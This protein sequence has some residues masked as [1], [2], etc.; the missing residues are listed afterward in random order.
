[1]RFHAGDRVV[2]RDREEILASLDR[3][4]ELESMP[5][6]VEMLQFC[7]RE[8]EVSAVAHKTCDTIHKTGGRRVARAIHLKDVRCD[9]SAHGQCQA[10]CLL[11]WKTEWL[12]PA[13]ERRDSDRRVTN[14]ATLGLNGLQAAG[15]CRDGDEP[16]YSCQATRLFTASTPLRWWDV[17]QYLADL[18]Y[19]NVGL[20]RFLRVA[21][22][23]ALHSLMSLPLGYRIAAAAYDVAHRAM[24]GR[25][26]PYKS[27]VIPHGRPTPTGSLGLSSGEWVEV[28][29]HEEIRETLTDRNFNRGMAFDPE[30]AQFCGRRFQVDRRVERIIDERT[31]RMMSMKSPCIVLDGVVCSSEYSQLRLFCPRQIQPYFREI[32]LRRASPVPSDAARPGGEANSGHQDRAT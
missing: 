3:S 2:V 22:L 11:F 9:G 12:R 4:G 29:P 7:G 21:A 1:M 26:T 20:V 18:W 14:Q 27:G 19:G 15:V 10:G 24:V 17:R 6:M 25:P 30:M 31:G 16:V 23:R 5:F 28:R 32:W 8:F 13:A